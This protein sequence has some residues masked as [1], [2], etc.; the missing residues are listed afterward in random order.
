MLHAHATKVEAYDVWCL[1]VLGDSDSGECHHSLNVKLKDIAASTG[2][3]VFS[4]L[5]LD[6]S[7]WISMYGSVQLSLVL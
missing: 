5:F 7:Q 3:S 6:A 4:P 1:C 2:I